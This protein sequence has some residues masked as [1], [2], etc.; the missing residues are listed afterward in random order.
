MIGSVYPHVT[1]LQEILS[2]AP[3][4][5]VRKL[6]HGEAAGERSGR[7]GSQAAVLWLPR[8]RAWVLPIPLTPACASKL[9]IFIW[10][11]NCNGP[12]A[13]HRLCL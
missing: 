7:A 5:P 10:G 3:N 4:L 11:L 1:P 9:G 13:E 6:S 12:V 8:G 2:L